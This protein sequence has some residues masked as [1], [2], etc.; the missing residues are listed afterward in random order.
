M[1]MVHEWFWEYLNV[2]HGR[3]ITPLLAT[4]SAMV[5]IAG[6]IFLFWAWRRW[7][8]H[9]SDSA[10]QYF[11]LPL[12][13]ALMIAGLTNPVLEVEQPGRLWHAYVF[14]WDDAGTAI[15]K[16]G[17]VLLPLFALLCWWLAVAVLAPNIERALVGRSAAVRGIADVAT[18]WVRRFNPLAGEASSRA[19]AVIGVLLA[20]FA[21]LYSGV[22]LMTEHGVVLWGSAF[23]PAI[24]FS[25]A[26]AGGAGL[27]WLLLP[28][29]SYLRDGRARP[30]H[31]GNPSA[32]W[33]ASLASTAL[34]LLWLQYARHFGGVELHRALALVDGPYRGLA[35]YW[36]FGLGTVL[37]SLL[38]FPRALRRNPL[39]SAVAAA[40]AVVG[41]FA[42]RYA[43]VIVGQAVPKSGAGYYL[44]TVP[45]EMWTALILD[46]AY[47][48]GWMALFWAVLPYGTGAK[49]DISTTTISKEAVS[50]G[51]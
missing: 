24:F 30:A 3:P 19:I 10:E 31:M 12:A 45:P 47:C 23:V 7:R 15:I 36:W 1:T 32:L 2:A 29:G 40:A 41:A 8:S 25:S 26:I 4:Y 34:W 49:K 6:A 22:F 16:F 13:V 50:H 51:G 20:V 37:P 27:L 39:V 44:Y 17:V 48:I 21:I 35:W 28:L 9:D 33:I 46:F 14:G 42:L 43:L 38:L 5:G 11:A 18:L